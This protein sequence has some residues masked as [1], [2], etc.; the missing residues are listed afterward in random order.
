M[1]NAERGE[2]TQDAS[3]T[4]LSN[5][6]PPNG[7]TP[8]FKGGA[9]ITQTVTPGGHVANTSQAYFPDYHR[10]FA[11]PSAFAWIALGTCF[12]Q[13]GL[14]YIQARGVGLQFASVL[15]VPYV[16]LGFILLS[17]STIF[18]FMTGHT[19]SATMFGVFTGYF[20]SFIVL[21]VPWFGITGSFDGVKPN[22]YAAGGAGTTE[23]SRITGIYLTGKS[24]CPVIC[25]EDP[26]TRTAYLIVLFF[27]IIAATRESALV[28]AILIAV[29]LSIILQVCYFLKADHSKTI[30]T[31]AGAF[32]FIG[33]LLSWYAG[34]ASLLT[35]DTAFFTL[36]TFD[37]K[38]KD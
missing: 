22:M 32:S 27:I 29:E 20:G 30:A 11:D 34:L 31:A 1:S 2:A 28:L 4:T 16:F 25:G 6:P 7:F 5:G 18:E 17:I 24:L 14:V 36:P 35:R 9:A 21:H 8:E 23:L 33:G 12:V 19:F 26:L 13:T 15:L 38:F 3:R 10:K 37:F